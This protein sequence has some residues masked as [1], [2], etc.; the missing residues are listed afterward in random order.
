M[1]TMTQ[2]QATRLLIG[3]A[4][5]A[6]EIDSFCPDNGQGDEA[7]NTKHQRADVHDVVSITL[8]DGAVLSFSTAECASRYATEMWRTP[9]RKQRKSRG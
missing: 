3:R 1:T 7:I 2:K 6:V 8:S 4:I 9:A 5:V